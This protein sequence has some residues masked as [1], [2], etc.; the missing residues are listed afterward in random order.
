[1]YGIVVTMYDDSIVKA[2]EAVKDFIKTNYD[3][4]PRVHQGYRVTT[5]S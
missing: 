2:M 3:V 5:G 1:M 4:Q